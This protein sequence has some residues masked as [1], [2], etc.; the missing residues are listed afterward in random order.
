MVG[1]F[2]S[3]TVDFN[4]VVF[5]DIN[6]FKLDDIQYAYF[7]SVAVK[8]IKPEAVD[9]GRLIQV[10]QVNFPAGMIVLNSAV[11][12]IMESSFL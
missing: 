10:F 8:F 11:L 4:S 1:N 9:E 7:L 2:H 3:Q 5:I 6:I 12:Y